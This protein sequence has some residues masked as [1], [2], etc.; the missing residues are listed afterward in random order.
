MFISKEVYVSVIFSDVAYWCLCIEFLHK[1]LLISVKFF[2]QF[3]TI[4]LYKSESQW[5]LAIDQPLSFYIK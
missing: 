3:F 5:N 4:P 1:D 2:D